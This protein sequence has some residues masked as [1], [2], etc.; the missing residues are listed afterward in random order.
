MSIDEVDAT[1]DLPDG[2]AALGQQADVHVTPGGTVA[3][4]IVLTFRFD[5]SLLPPDA[6]ES[7]VH[8]FRNGVEVPACAG[9]PSAVPDP[10]VSDRALAERFGAHAHAAVQPWL[11]TPEEYARRIRELV[12]DV[13]G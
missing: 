7:T 8:L 10:C 3:D 12:D 1:Q 9:A 5:A 11:A 6:D 13:A 2:F 4:P